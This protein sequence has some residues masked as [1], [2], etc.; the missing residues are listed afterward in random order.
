MNALLGSAAC[1]HL[2]P[3]VRRPGY[4]WPA[5][6]TGIVHLGVGAF[7]RAHQALYTDEAIA[8]RGGDWGIVAVALRHAEVPQALAAQDQ[9][10]TVEV[11]ADTPQY[12][13]IGALRAS[14]FAAAQPALL[15]EALRSPQTHVV[16]LTITEKGYCLGQ[17]GE[18]DAAHPDIE[19]DLRH[20]AEP[21]TAIGWLAA[22]LLA[23]FDTHQM[24]MTVISCDNLQC[25]GI[26]LRD[27]V[28]AF[29]AR[30]YPKAGAWVQHHVCFPQTVVDCIVPA[31]TEASR[32]RVVR[33]LGAR[34]AACVQREPYSQW[35]IENRFAG[36]TPAWQEAGVE[37]VD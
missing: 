34:D 19:W 12:R 16:T 27:A 31:G 7:H 22:G 17:N 5:L 37:I 13:V 28:T 6:R 21:K 4:D 2:P 8:R 25:N 35:V 1:A 26:R 20:P 29:I 11:L 24:P 23:R 3:D 36:P 10:Y 15:L 18:L 9:L 30:A 32:A 14:L 33:A